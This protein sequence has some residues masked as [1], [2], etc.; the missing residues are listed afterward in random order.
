MIKL[1][2]PWEYTFENWQP[3][4]RNANLLYY[5]SELLQQLNIIDENEFSNSIY[6]S[7]KACSALHISID[8]NFAHVYINQN[9]ELISDWKLSLLACYLI[10]IN[11]NPENPTIAKAQVFFALKNSMTNT[12]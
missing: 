1:Y 10:V 9:N 7:I 2:N 12:I 4:T 11:C 8:E 5:A 6:R 3:P